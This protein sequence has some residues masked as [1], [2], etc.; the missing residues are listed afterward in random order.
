VNYTNKKEYVPPEIMEGTK[1]IK[2]SFVQ[3]L[4]D[5]EA[6]ITP[7]LLDDE[8][9]LKGR[10]AVYFGVKS[11]WIFS[12]WEICKELGAEPTKT[13]Y[14]DDLY[15]FVISPRKYFN[16]GLTFNIARKRELLFKALVR[17]QMDTTKIKP[18]KPLSPGY[19]TNSRLSDEDVLEIRSLA[20]ITTYRKL[21]ENFNVCEATIKRIVDGKTFKHLLGNE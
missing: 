11:E 19:R 13:S 10:T 6:C 12:V 4:M 15:R 7:R 9:R 5:S 20:R 2:I 3:G 1:D 8:G 17:H 14:R 16:A 18:R 21:A